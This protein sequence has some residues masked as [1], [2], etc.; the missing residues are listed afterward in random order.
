MSGKISSKLNGWVLLEGCLKW[1]VDVK[2]LA[3]RMEMRTHLRDAFLA[4]ST[5]SVGKI[6]N[7]MCLISC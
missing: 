5:V 2:E 6:L 4:S 7:T 3:S 1:E